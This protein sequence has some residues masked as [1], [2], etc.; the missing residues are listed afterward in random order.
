MSVAAVFRQIP[1]V[2]NYPRE[3]KRRVKKRLPIFFKR[4][5]QD[6]AV[7]N[8]NISEQKSV[9]SR[10]VAQEKRH[11]V[12]T[13]QPEM[14][15][16]LTAVLDGGNDRKNRENRHQQKRG[17]LRKKPV[18]TVCEVGDEIHYRHRAAQEN[19]AEI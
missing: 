18:K 2:K 17:R 12:S 19:R 8:R 14:R 6:S 15:D 7:Y 9:I 13:D 11:G 10:I 4:N 1:A 16:D 5:R 3:T